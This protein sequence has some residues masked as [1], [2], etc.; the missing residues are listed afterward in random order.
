MTTTAP[1]PAP[2][3]AHATDLRNLAAKLL[4][5]LWPLVAKL[6]LPEPVEEALSGVVALA[7][8]ALTLWLLVLLLTRTPYLVRLAAFGLGWAVAYEL[9]MD[10]KGWA[11]KDVLLRVF[12]GLVPALVLIWLVFG[13]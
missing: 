10:P 13:A 12:L 11:W 2:Q 6:H 1:A 8:G 5:P 4:G 9:W 3:P 7:L